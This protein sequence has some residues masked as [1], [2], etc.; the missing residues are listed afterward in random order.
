MPKCPRMALSDRASTA[1]LWSLRYGDLSL[2]DTNYEKPKATLQW[3]SKRTKLTVSQLQFRLRQH[4]A[5]L[6]SA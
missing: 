3:I 1:H 5:F 6:E 4:R 2:A